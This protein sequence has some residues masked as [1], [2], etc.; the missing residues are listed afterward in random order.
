MLRSDFKKGHKIITQGHHDHKIK[1]VGKVKGSKDEYDDSFFFCHR[2]A[3]LRI[4]RSRC[5][6]NRKRNGP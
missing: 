3:K 2:E 1:D 5:I 6:L 4:E